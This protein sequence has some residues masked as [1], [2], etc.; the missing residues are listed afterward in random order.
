MTAMRNIFNPFEIV[1]LI[2]YKN[3]ITSITWEY[4]LS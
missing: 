3:V 2:K 1:K 4:V